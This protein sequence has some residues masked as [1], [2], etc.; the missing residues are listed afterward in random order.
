MMKGCL[1]PRMLIGTP[2]LTSD[3]SFGLDISVFI[4]L[5]CVLM[6]GGSLLGCRGSLFIYGL[7]LHC[8]TLHLIL[9]G[10]VKLLIIEL[11]WMPC[12]FKYFYLCVDDENKFNVCRIW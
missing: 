12:Y 4:S 10:H 1:V 11:S 8:L 3:P 7:S 2:T 9:D 5:F 6:P